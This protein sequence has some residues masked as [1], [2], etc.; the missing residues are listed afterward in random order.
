M[1]FDITEIVV[2]LIGLL[3]AI[4]TAFV[5]PAIKNKTNKDQ[6][7]MIKSLAIAGVQA[8]E[9]IYGASKGTA[10]FEYV[11]QYLKK[12]CDKLGIK[13]DNQTIKVAIE[14]AWKVLGLDKKIK[15]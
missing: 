6:F 1:Q 15:K 7:E 11:T 10:K 9:I 12:E 5:I 8:A 13:I 4:I 3:S 2:A 14:N